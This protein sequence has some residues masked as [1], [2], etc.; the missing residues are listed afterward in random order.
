M[1]IPTHKRPE[2]CRRL[3][4]ALGTQSLPANEFEVIVVDDA[5]GDETK[6][7]LVALAPEVPYR[8]A[9][10]SLD[11]NSGPAV[12]RNVGWRRAEASLVAFIDDDCVPTPSW[13]EA[14]LLGF[15]SASR[16]GVVQGPAVPPDGYDIE[17][18][19]RW[20]HR[21]EIR[22]P[23]P[24]FEACNV[25]YDRQ[26]LEDA[27]G[28]DEAIGWW[29]E[30]TALGYEVLAQGWRSAWAP[31]AAV[32]H[33]VTERGWGWW[34]RMALFESHLVVLAA[35]YPL[36]RER[37]FWRQ[38][39]FRQ[40]NFLFALASVAAVAGLRWRPAL[41]LATP[42]LWKTRQSPRDPKAVVHWVEV[43]GVDAA[44]A[45]GHLAGSVQCRTL[46]L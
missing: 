39:A 35:R 31:E 10:V 1:V 7:V 21:Q 4:E 16:V 11:V 43:V 42:Y 19:P 30:D 40:E 23:S 44:R 8:M 46:V 6:E 14:G 13:L 37:A 33:D 45:A 32:V 15:A 34:A 27:G 2:R 12:A 5:S 9:I 18:W 41:L 29:G 36:F 25:F 3:L 17:E 38:W 26:A 22:S 20:H 24:F 28:F